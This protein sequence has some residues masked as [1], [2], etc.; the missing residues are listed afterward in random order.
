MRTMMRMKAGT[1]AAVVALGA[2]LPTSAQEL[3]TLSVSRAVSGQEQINVL[4]HYGAGELTLS[5]A[6]SGTLYSMDLTWDERAFQPV[7]EFDGRQLEIGTR[8]AERGRNLN[9]DGDRLGELKVMLAQGVPMDLRLDFGA[10]RAVV[11][12]GGLELRD[13][14]LKT[15]ASESTLDV[16]RPNPG[17][18][19]QA[20]LDIGAAQF[21]A[22]NLGNLNLERLEVNAGVG[23]IK[24]DF[25]GSLKHDVVVDIDMGLGSLELTIPEGVGVRV[26]RSS[27]LTTFDAEGFDRRDGVYYSSNWDSA[28]RQIEI[29]I[30]AAFGSIR[31]V[32]TR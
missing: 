32:R 21:T 5:P 24:L 3:K 11:D 9:L 6:R 16:S 15:G 30:K 4:V 20:H 1:L 13:L 25:A 31:V 17:S 12:L 29:D 28:D 27:F 10:G 14:D 8:S 2:A 7:N 19:R 22:H 18:L 26:E 23:D